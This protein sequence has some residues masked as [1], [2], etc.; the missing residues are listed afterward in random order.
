VK[1][2]ILFVDDDQYLLQ[3][4]RRHLHTMEAQ[5]T[6]DFVSDADAAIALVQTRTFD[7]VVTDLRMPGTDGAQLLKK[8]R[9]VQ[10]GAIR[11]ILSGYAE[12]RSLFSSVSIA[13]QFLSKPCDPGSILNVMERAR[14]ARAMLAEPGLRAAIGKLSN[15]PSPP[16]LYLRLT[17]AMSRKNPAPAEISRILEEDPAMVAR[18]LSLTNSAFFASANKVRRVDQ[19]VHVLGLETLRTLAMSYALFRQAESSAAMLPLLKEYK[20]HAQTMA[21]EAMALAQADRANAGL[22]QEAYAAGVLSGIGRF[23]LCEAAPNIMNGL[24]KLG[25]NAALSAERA[26]FGASS[27]AIGAYLL[28][29]WGFADTIVEAVLLQ[30]VPPDESMRNSGRPV[31]YV[32]QATLKLYGEAKIEATAQKTTAETR[33]VILHRGQRAAAPS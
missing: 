6:C 21:Q 24:A 13:H 19:A 20:W 11:V 4:L 5:W 7:V 8:V 32:Q 16:D 25:H 28:A 9:E 23:A 33:P 3:S 27:E 10:P 15:L 30:S 12:E 17:A 1:L 29:L 26:A 2:A 18:L 14:A 31:Y 22:A